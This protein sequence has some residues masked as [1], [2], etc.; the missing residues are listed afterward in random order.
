MSTL[1][2]RLEK[3]EKILAPTVA[4]DAGWGT[5]ATCRDLLLSRAQER[6]ELFVEEIKNQLETIGP[7]GLW[8]EVA[9]DYLWNRGFVQRPTESFAETIGRALGIGS[10]ALRTRI[11]EGRL[12][13]DLVN[14]LAQPAILR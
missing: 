13:M 9:R 3:L 4:K 14:K 8:I 11:Q 6:G 10:A 12:G 7:S 2:R 5:M 1:R